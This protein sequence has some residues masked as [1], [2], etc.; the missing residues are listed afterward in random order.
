MSGLG[1]NALTGI[2]YKRHA[3]AWVQEDD[4]A[5]IATIIPLELYRRTIV[6]VVGKVEEDLILC[7]AR[8][9][10]SMWVS[11]QTRCEGGGVGQLAGDRSGGNRM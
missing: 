6:R 8:H 9:N 1:E 4:R 3:L 5:C 7:R 10:E 11:E 2:K